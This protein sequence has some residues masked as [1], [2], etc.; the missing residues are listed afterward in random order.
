MENNRLIK[1]VIAGSLFIILGMFFF[2]KF[3]L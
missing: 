1:G 2:V 3:D